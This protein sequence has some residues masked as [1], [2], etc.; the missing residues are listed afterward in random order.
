[1]S[2]TD[3]ALFNDCLTSRVLRPIEE[4]IRHGDLTQQRVIV[5]SAHITNGCYLYSRRPVRK[6]DEQ[7][8]KV[9]HSNAQKMGMTYDE[10]LD[11]SYSTE[12][13]HYPVFRA[14]GLQLYRMEDHTKHHLHNVY[15]R[16]HLMPETPALLAFDYVWKHRFQLANVGYPQISQGFSECTRDKETGEYIVMTLYIKLH[17][18]LCP[19]G[20]G[21]GDELHPSH[22]VVAGVSGNLGADLDSTNQLSQGGVADRLLG[23][24]LPSPTLSF[25]HYHL[26]NSSGANLTPQVL[27]SAEQIMTPTDLF[28]RHVYS[29]EA[30]V[31]IVGLSPGRRVKTSRMV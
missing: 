15:G 29:N 2:T 14:L 13:P 5:P 31:D 30:E 27:V 16:E 8:M 26:N 11:A 12:E 22:A 7:E 25:A 10:Y 9:W 1:M 6:T 17:T 24:P 19:Q 3:D 21:C 23:N 4:G 28:A 20:D 18:L